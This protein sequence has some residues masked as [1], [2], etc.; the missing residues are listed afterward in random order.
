MCN[1]KKLHKFQHG[2]EVCFKQRFF[3]FKAFYNF[4][5]QLIGMLCITA[6]WLRPF[7]DCIDL[8]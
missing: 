7:L 8:L 6:G 5:T 2:L 4:N 1:K 3:S